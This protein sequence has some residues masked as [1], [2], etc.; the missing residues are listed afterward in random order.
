[1]DDALELWEML[2]GASSWT[3]AGKLLTEIERVHA[4]A[5]R[6]VKEKP[7]M[8]MFFQKGLERMTADFK[9]KLSKLEWLK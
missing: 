7:Y 5:E 3:D 8:R 4:L 6:I 1:M 9:Q 2:R